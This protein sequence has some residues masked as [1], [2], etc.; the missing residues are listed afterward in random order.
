[1]SQAAVNPVVRLFS[2][3]TF[4]I[5]LLVLLFVYMTIGSAGLIYPVHPN[6]LDSDAWVH[7]QVRQWRPFEMTEFEWFHWWPFDLLLG[8]LA[9]NIVV[10]T[11]RRIPLRVVNL[12]VWMVHVGILVLIAGSVIYF[13]TKVE[14]ETPVVRRQVLL[15]LSG[16]DGTAGTTASMAAMP[17][18][19]TTLGSGP[20]S[21]RIQVSSIDP[22]W[23]LLSGP[24]KGKRGYSVNF[25]VQ[26]GSGRFIRQVIAGYP[27]YT[28]DLV[29]TQDE[30]QPV[31]RAVKELGKPLVDEKLKITLDFQG[32]D[33]FYL[34][35]DL[36]KSWA[37]YI[38]RPGQ[39]AWV[40]RPI[41]GL[42]LY[43]DA[44]SSA[45]DV[46][47][48]ATGQVDVHPISVDIP[49]VAAD[50]P[51]KDVVLQATGYLR[52]AQV[53]GR[54]T[55]GG[56][57]DPV[58]PVAL[59][60]VRADGDRQSQYRLVARD[61][62]QRSADGGII[63]LRQISD[64][65]Q[66]DALKHEP[67][68]R[69]SI[70][71][72]NIVLGERV[73][74]AVSPDPNAP[75]RPIGP[76]AEGYAYKVVS[77]QDDLPIGGRDLSVAILEMKTPKGTFRRWVFSDPNLSRDLAPGETPAQAMAHGGQS[78][79]DDSIEVT[80]A[81]GN[82]LAAVLLVAGPE[83]N[84]LRLVDTFNR[85]EPRVIP[86]EQGQPVEL[87][88]SLKLVVSAWMP[89]AV[90]ERRPQ[91]V[92]VEQRIR[93]ARELFAMMQL[94]GPVE[95]PQWLKY[96]PWVF[97][98]P[99]D[100]LRRYWFEPTTVTLKDGSQL[101]VLFARQRLPL[102]ATVALDEFVL[103]T[104]VGGFSGDTSSI[105]N[106]TSMV[107]FRDRAP[108]GASAWGLP[109][110]VSVNDP[111]EHD[112]YWFFQSQ[113]DPPEESRQGGMASA[114]LNYTVLGV[115]NRN[116]VWVQMAGCVL[117]VLGMAYAFYVK[118]VIKRRNKQAVLEE[119]QTAKAEHR[120]PHF[121]HT[122]LW[123]VVLLAT[124]LLGWCVPGA[125]AQVAQ[126]S[127]AAAPQVPFSK[128]VDLT[129]L[130]SV[131]VHTE[132][133]LKSFGSY[134]NSQMQFVTGSKR[135]AGQTPDFT[136]LDMMFR[137]DAYKDADCIYVKNREVRAQLAQALLRAD[138]LL[139]ER[140]KAFES[141]GLISP[142]LLQ[143]PELDQ[144][145]RMLEA[146]LVR[147]AKQM[148]ALKTA[149]AVMEPMNLL[150]GLRMLPPGDGSL[151]SPWT[152]I[153]DIMLLGA[154]PAMVPQDMRNLIP[155]P[156]PGLDPDVQR[157]VAS[158][159][160]EMGS[161]WVRGDAARVNKGVAEVARL[162]PTLKPSIY[163]DQ[164]RLGWESWYFRNG[165]MSWVWM[166]YLLSIIF[167]LLG[168]VYRWKRATTLG[169]VVFAAAFGL[170]TAAVGLRW[171]ISGRWPNSNMFEAVTTAAWMGAALAVI[172][173]LLLRRTRMHGLLA[174]GGAAGGMVALMAA[175][176]LPVQ[177][178]PNISNMM[179]V[180]HD[181]WLYI[182]T[183]VII[184][185][186]AIIF[187]AAI[188]A[189]AYVAVRL[190]G[191]PAVYARVGGAGAAL[192][193]AQG[194][195]GAVP[196]ASRKAELAEVLDGVTMLLIEVSFVMLWA[197]IV[198]G[199]IWADHSWGRPWGWDPKE[200]FALNTFVI[201]ALLI[202]VRWKVRDKGLW[203]AVL[204]IVG[205]AV[206]LFNWIVINFV[207]S[208]LHSYA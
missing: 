137:P 146:D 182:H 73:R 125:Q 54:W 171:Y 29:F 37:L 99:E 186:Y 183:N 96:H 163:P 104:N 84:R 118:P 198:M 33:W 203:T 167:L 82:G 98:R 180:L 57:E 42:P 40:E 81:P 65:S 28:E 60:T 200:V 13:G 197:G 126:Q 38:R 138:P 9:A 15:E 204:A 158:A 92:P 19:A 187:M 168:L 62:Q 119:I 161:G 121:T 71:G 83:A 107:R 27:Q 189:L 147:S 30:K 80:Y 59:V 188:S 55:S 207:I 87:A 2:S 12:G 132:G 114:G 56:P 34:K 112:G 139:A 140:M 170:Q 141:S 159:W 4:G 176:L 195:S 25:M 202:H 151:N 7:A 152:S 22:A 206:M 113:W 194:G 45:E 10:T 58:N 178:N 69:F 35:N 190:L 135:I 17:G 43:N 110:R 162:L 11:L 173:E 128:Q 102:P 86:L 131:A 8:L 66:L 44:V 88:S 101:E 154:D 97:D 192:A 36:N 103:D 95:K 47:P 174:L 199:A 193:M 1:M 39:T 164:A 184:F 196:P 155:D 70:P 201:F 172:A 78:W 41:H 175:H 24:D 129:P 145:R 20:D 123:G 89:R 76:A 134:A 205:A 108:N 142:A 165:N 61:P 23:E 90:V 5:T 150:G 72:K 48:P 79:V 75:M 26:S 185:S 120:P 52:Y 16:T 160:R 77:V 116:G 109:E 31:K 115:G 14:G 177:L 51:A 6:L 179:P 144:V 124:A 149:Q 191:G 3:V 156:L 181:V 94:N 105:R 136:Y 67:T 21:Y 153:G 18:N 166:V 148:D 49:A 64:E 106:Y 32:Q 74:D 63:A 127:Q 130:G 133:R 85:T 50:D 143:R 111:V 91:Q 117:A 46:M 68:L 169:L 122:G 157:A 208:G 100:V 53:A 93:D